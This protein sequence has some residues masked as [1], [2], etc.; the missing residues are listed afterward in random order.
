MRCIFEGLSRVPAAPGSPN[1]IPGES[2]FISQLK[3]S[4]GPRHY[5]AGRTKKTVRLSRL[6]RRNTVPARAMEKYFVP[7]MTLEAI[8]R[9]RTEA[10]WAAIKNPENTLRLPLSEPRQSI[11]LGTIDATTGAFTYSVPARKHRII[12]TALQPLAR[13]DRSRRPSARRSRNF[14]R[15]APVLS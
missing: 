12:V 2:N 1:F 7:R 15:P 8:L 4:R 13:P 11:R 9:L 5:L 14:W 6:V 3:R 10:A